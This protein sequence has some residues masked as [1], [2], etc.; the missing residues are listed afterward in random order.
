MNAGHLGGKHSLELIPRLYAFDHG[1]HETKRVTE[2][3][4]TGM[5]QLLGKAPNK[6][7]ILSSEH[8]DEVLYIKGIEAPVWVIP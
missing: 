1:K 7:T 5:D 2:Q 4:G 6:I 8:I 3:T